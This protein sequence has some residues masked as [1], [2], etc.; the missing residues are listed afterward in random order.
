MFPPGLE[1]HRPPAVRGGSWSVGWVQGGPPHSKGQC[2][3]R[4]IGRGRSSLRGEGQCGGRGAASAG[5]PPNRC[6][7]AH[8]GGGPVGRVLPRALPGVHQVLPAGRG[9]LAS[10]PGPGC[11]PPLPQKPTKALLAGGLQALGPLD[12]RGRERPLHQIHV[13]GQYLA[14]L[15]VTELG[16]TGPD[17]QVAMSQLVRGRFGPHPLIAAVGGLGQILQQAAHTR[18][19]W[20]PGPRHPPKGGATSTACLRPGTATAAR[21]L[22]CLDGPQ[23]QQVAQALLP[24]RQAA[25]GRAPGCSSLW[26]RRGPGQACSPLPRS[27]GFLLGPAPRGHHVRLLRM[28]PADLDPAT[29][30]AAKAVTPLVGTAASPAPHCIRCP[31]PVAKTHR[32][33]QL[34]GSRVFPQQGLLLAPAG[35]ASPFG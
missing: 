10:A 34:G 26:R 19:R 6:R 3:R 24:I 8:G 21:P 9:G 27:T 22:A 12:K 11:P 7:P 32:P 17:L 16:T 33:L 25:S 5:T 13:V 15:S 23:I 28:S 18:A 30:N 20:R 1:A 4:G 31:V 35:R 2:L 29:G 14:S